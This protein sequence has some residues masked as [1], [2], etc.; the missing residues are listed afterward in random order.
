MSGDFGVD[1]EQ[2]RQAARR[3]EAEAADLAGLG[4]TVLT[5]V[6][7]GHVGGAFGAVAAPYRLAFER[8]GRN[9]AELGAAAAAISARLTEAAAAYAHID[10]ESSVRTV[11]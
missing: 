4:D 5:N 11:R 9:L 7:E 3:Y 6:G 10:E 2:L 8:F 1:V